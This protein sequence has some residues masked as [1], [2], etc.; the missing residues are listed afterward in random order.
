L[1]HRVVGR[2]EPAQDLEPLCALAWACDCACQSRRRARTEDVGR[3]WA[4]RG[5]WLCGK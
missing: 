5:A 1:E 4:R 2:S 3:G